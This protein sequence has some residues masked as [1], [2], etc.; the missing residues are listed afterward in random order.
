MRSG[1][2][3][4]EKHPTGVAV[5]L[6]FPI[7]EVERLVA[8][9]GR[10]PGHCH[11]GEAALLEGFALETALA[12]VVVPGRAA[13]ADVEVDRCDVVFT[14]ELEGIAAGLRRLA[15]GILPGSI[16]PRRPGIAGTETAAGLPPVAVAEGIG[17]SRFVCQRDHRHL[18]KVDRRFDHRIGL[19]GPGGD[20]DD[21]VVVVADSFQARAGSEDDLGRRCIGGRVGRPGDEE[22]P[23]REELRRGLD[24]RPLGE[25][26]EF[27]FLGSLWS[28]GRDRGWGEDWDGGGGP[29]SAPDQEQPGAGHEGGTETADGK[30]SAAPLTPAS[31]ERC[32]LGLLG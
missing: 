27:G 7:L 26:H 15:A 21:P 16:P 22:D 17:R 8:V 32:N 20:E 14:E 2:E 24:L 13:D 5:T 10:L 18:G 29:V 30:P 11:G 23:S 31:D 19:R 28:R 3:R 12:W 1:D 6:Q 25:H 4:I 9:A